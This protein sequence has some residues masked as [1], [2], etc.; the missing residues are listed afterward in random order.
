MES[1]DDIRWRQRLAN[2]GLALQRLTEAV[3]LARRNPA[4]REHI[5]R[6]GQPFA[7]D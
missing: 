4:L 2:Y 3:R 5:E 1:R 6:V 7:A